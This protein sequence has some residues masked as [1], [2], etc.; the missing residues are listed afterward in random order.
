MLIR[1]TPNQVAAIVNSDDRIKQA[2]ISLYLQKHPPVLV[3]EDSPSG[4]AGAVC[5][6]DVVKR[7]VLTGPIGVAPGGCEVALGAGFG[8]ASGA[9]C[10]ADAKCEEADLR[11]TE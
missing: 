5:N 6:R 7:P 11:K 4:G 2:V 3:I 10:E 1:L 8:G 9:Q